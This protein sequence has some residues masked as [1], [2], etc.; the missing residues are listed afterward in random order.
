MSR[1]KLAFGSRVESATQRRMEAIMG[2]RG[3]VIRIILDAADFLWHVA[4]PICR[5]PVIG[6]TGRTFR[7]IRLDR[8]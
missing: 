4:S 7:R 2:E 8:G 6:Q 5:M 1:P 3:L